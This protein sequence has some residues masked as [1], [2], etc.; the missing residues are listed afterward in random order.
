MVSHLPICRFAICLF[1]TL[2]CLSACTFTELLPPAI[3]PVPTFTPSP[4][5]PPSPTPTA[6]PI[7]PLA[8][9]IRWPRPVLP[10]LPPAPIAVELVPPPGVDV[11]AMV[12][13]GVLAP[14]GTI[15]ERFVLEPQGGNL[16]VAAEPLQLP[17]D[18][19]AGAWRLVIAVN[20]PLAVAGDWELLFHPAPLRLHDLTE[21]LPA[22]ATLRV[23][24][25]FVEVTAQGDVWAGGRVWRYGEG[26][27][28]LWWAPGPTEPLLFNNAFV[29]LE[30]THDPEAS[31]R[32]LDMV[33]TEWQGRTAFLFHEKWRGS[34]GGPSEAWVVQG[35]DYWLYVLR[36]RAVS[37]EEIPSLI[38]QVGETFTLGEE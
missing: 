7:P 36:V 14:D 23:P 20:S 4:T 11:E 25:D 32:V 21:V 3:T 33:E 29:M 13:A 31:P 28:A 38:R 37:A 6:T 35:D 19:P 2:L 30:A 8:L 15:Y 5:P 18:P 22:A 10:L 1:V 12:S 24:Q 9:T 26:E 16:Y 34:E 17:L 27:L